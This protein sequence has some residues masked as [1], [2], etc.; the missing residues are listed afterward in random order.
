MTLIEQARQVVELGKRATGLPWWILKTE[1]LRDWESDD[2]IKV[3]AAFIEGPQ[4]WPDPEITFWRVEDAELAVTAANTAPALAEGVLRIAE[5][6]G[7]QL[8]RQINR[9]PTVCGH[10]GTGDW[11]TVISDEM[12]RELL[13]L[14]G[15]DGQ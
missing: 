4:H 9:P 14:L 5:I 3:P 8:K 1:C 2:G 10:H 15:K 13:K 6:L 7:P 12:A 11:M